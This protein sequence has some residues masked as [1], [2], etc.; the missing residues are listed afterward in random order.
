M[1]D[2]EIIS[3]GKG[4]LEEPEEKAYLDAVKGLDAK[5][6]VLDDDPTGIQTV[7]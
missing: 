5:I 2:E 3:S 6:V 7:H 4:C 1:R